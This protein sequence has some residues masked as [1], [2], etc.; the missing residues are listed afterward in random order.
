MARSVCSGVPDQHRQSAYSRG[1]LVAR[2]S[3]LNPRE[4]IW[5]EHLFRSH[6]VENTGHKLEISLGLLLAVEIVGKRRHIDFLGVAH[7]P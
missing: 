7:I 2:Q 5:V 3:D 6:V 4:H 1:Y